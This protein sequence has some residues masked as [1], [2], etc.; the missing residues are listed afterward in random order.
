MKKLVSIMESLELGDNLISFVN[1]IPE[2]I[3]HS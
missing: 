1:R 2:I 3:H